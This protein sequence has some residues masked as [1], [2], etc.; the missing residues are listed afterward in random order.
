M[1]GGKDSEGEL[2]MKRDRVLIVDDSSVFR[3]IIRKAL[4]PDPAIEVVATAANG[5]IALRMVEGKSPDAVILDVEMPE[6]DGIETLR[7][8]RQRWP[9][10]KVIMFSA[11]TSKG[12]S[13]T[14]EALSLGAADFVTKPSGGTLQENIDAIQR[15]LVPRVKA[16]LDHPV[17]TESRKPL[18]TPPQRP[19][20]APRRQLANTRPP[21]VAI[22]V[23]TGGPNAL[24]EVLSHLVP[25]FRSPIVITQHMPPLFTEQLAARLDRVCP[26]SV[27]EAKD[28]QRVEPGNV[29]IAPGDYHMEVHREAGSNEP[30]IRTHQGPKECSCR[31]STDVMFRSIADSYG[32]NTIA[33]ILTGMGQDGYKGAQILKGCN[34]YIIAQDQATCVVYGM[35]SFIVNGGLAD[36]VLPLGEVATH[37]AKLTQ[38]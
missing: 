12:A 28:G 20:I 15:E 5:A 13:S 4:E 18:Q 7:Q 2:Y 6:M 35:P 23:S 29:Y 33:V 30:V 8:I 11:H 19:I 14:F 10:I 16:L 9:E 17:E 31:P 36:A 38:K 25:G 37:L 27:C 26:L 32:S 22:G 3:Q 34:A 1:T 24:Q 21:L